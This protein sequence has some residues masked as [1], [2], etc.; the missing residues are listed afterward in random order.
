M[1]PPL[2]VY[3]VS[4]TFYFYPP[5]FSRA[6]SLSWVSHYHKPTCFPSTH[7]LSFFTVFLF[8]YSF[9]ASTFKE[10]HLFCDFGKKKSP[11]HSE[12]RVPRRKPLTSSHLKII[13]TLQ[14]M[15]DLN[16][17]PY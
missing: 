13:E 12:G 1:S 8:S 17:I 2:I 16:C 5:L 7:F 3:I 4:S 14:K 11:S 9:F 6:I 10:F 15:T